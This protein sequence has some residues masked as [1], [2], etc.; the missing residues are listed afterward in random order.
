ME[1]RARVGRRD[2]RRASP[3][4]Q[5]AITRSIAAG[6]ELGAVAEDDDRGL[7]SG[8][9]A[10]RPQRREAPGPRSQSGQRH[11]RARRPRARARRAT[12]THVV[13]RAAADALEHGLEQQRAAWASRTGSRRR[14]PH[15]HD[16]PGRIHV[17]RRPTTLRAPGGRAGARGRP[18]TRCPGAASRGRGRPAQS[19]SHGIG[20]TPA[21]AR[22]VSSPARAAATPTSANEKRC[23]LHR[24]QVGAR[25]RLRHLELEDQL[26]GLER[27]HVAVVLGR[28]P[29][30]V[31]DAGTRAG[32]CAAVA[33][34]AS[35]AAAG[36]DGCA[37]A[38]RSLPKIACSRCAPSRAWQSEP[39][40]RKHG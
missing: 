28:Q 7:G 24:L 35:S 37:D 26:A 22:R 30:E 23:P 14:P 38:Q 18:C 25:L 21:S 19:S 36:S 32:R 1:P 27:G 5:A 31:G 4:R 12:T 15:E 17:L 20:A 13:H 8:G 40:C 39:P 10:C 2:D 11:G 29:V 3:A 6:L 16:G 34:S 33:P 9:S